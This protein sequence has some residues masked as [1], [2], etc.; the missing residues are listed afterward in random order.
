MDPVVSFTSHSGHGIRLQNLTRWESPT[1]LHFSSM[2]YF[3]I[4][5]RNDLG[6]HVIVSDFSMLSARPYLLKSPTNM[7]IACCS[8]YEP[9]E[10]TM[11]LSAY[12]KPT[13]RPM[14]SI[15]PSRGTIW[16]STLMTRQVLMKLSFTTLNSDG[17][18]N[19]TCVVTL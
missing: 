12:K 2:A 4:S 9:I 11:P 6:W 14:V 10:P 3:Y 8:L 1:L 19:N 17:D 7:F 18:T 16:S 15:S 5:A 13:H